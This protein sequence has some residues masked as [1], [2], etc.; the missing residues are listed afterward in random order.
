MDVVDAVREAHE[1][2]WGE[3]SR[4]AVFRAAAGTIEIYKWDAAFSAEEVDFYTTIGGSAFDMPLGS[5]GYRVEYYT[6]FN[7]GRDAVA[8]SLAALGLYGVRTGESVDHGHTIPSDGP[9]WPGTDMAAW[10]I[11]RPEEAILPVIHLA[12]GIHVEFLQAVPIF[13]SERMFKIAHGLNSLMD[14]WEGS[15]VPFW[16]PDRNPQPRI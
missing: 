13:E 12:G 3:P 10:L 15:L 1:A 9:L 16:N 8:S 11:L 6:G 2:R 4:R 5:E 7:P 14:L